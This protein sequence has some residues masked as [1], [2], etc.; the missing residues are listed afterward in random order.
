MK[1][2]KY[3][4][5]KKEYN[6]PNGMLTSIWGPSLWHVLHTISVNYPVNPTSDDKAHYKNFI[7]SLKYILPCKYCRINFTKNLKIV[8]LNTK[9]LKNRE[10]FSKWMYKLH[11]TLNR[12]L[13]KKSGMKFRDVQDR[14]EH[15]RAR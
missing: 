9:S 7:T 15:F 2:Q 14:Y 4:F 11:E 10:N 3:V 13:G 8:P 6:N 12:S 5:T 1:K